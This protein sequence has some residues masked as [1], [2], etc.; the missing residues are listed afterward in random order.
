MNNGKFRVA[1]Y[2]AATT[3][4]QTGVHFSLAPCTAILEQGGD[5]DN[6]T[7]DQEAGAVR[8]NVGGDVGGMAVFEEVARV[9]AA[10]VLFPSGR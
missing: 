6:G 1:T 9:G 2:F 5:I 3:Q 10:E 8:G 4:L 7:T